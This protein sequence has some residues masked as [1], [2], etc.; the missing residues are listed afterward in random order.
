[1]FN[2]T[3]NKLYEDH[4]VLVEDNLIKQI[5]ANPIVKPVKL[6]SLKVKVKR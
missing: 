3:E 1:M 6:P 2:G 5:S 4:H